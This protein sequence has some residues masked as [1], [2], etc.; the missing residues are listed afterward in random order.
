MKA[1]PRQHLAL[2]VNVIALLIL[3]WLGYTI[4]TRVYTVAIAPRPIDQSEIIARRKKIDTTEFQAA[5]DKI[6]DK[7]TPLTAAQLQSIGNPFE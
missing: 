1:W 4:Y 3:C 7:Q 5:L 2:I 6:T